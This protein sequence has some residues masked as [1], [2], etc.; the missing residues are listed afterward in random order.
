MLTIRQDQV[1]AF[2]QHHLQKFEDEMV[3]HL[4]NFSPRH[5]KVM[6]EADG[7]RVIRLGIDQAEKYGF[8]N[9]GPVRFYIELM[10][11]FGSFF[12][13]DPQHPWASAVLTDPDS[14]DQNVRAD[15]LY[16]AVNEYMALVVEPERRHL[17]EAVR[18]LMEARFED[19]VQPGANL[20]EEIL[21]VLH[22]VCPARCEYVGESAL[23][24]LV[25]H[26]FGLARAYG[27]ESDKGKVLMVILT[28]VVGHGFPKDPLNGW[29]VR[30]L[31]SERWPEPSKRV[32]ELASKSLLYLKHILA[33][34][35]R[36]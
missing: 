8:I 17:R 30:R 12:D 13:T 28:F 22:S 20:E 33:G 6:G 15:S 11:M 25:Q 31:N 7:R 29:I 24:R 36:A 18:P 1:E 16:A 5:W 10:S 2:R 3:E 34:G 14:M 9:R 19:V 21:R 27:F 4:K 35:A 23:R 32:D 26:G